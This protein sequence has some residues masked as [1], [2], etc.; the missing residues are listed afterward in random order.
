MLWTF[1]LFFCRISFCWC[2]FFGGR[3]RKVREKSE[4]EL[5]KTRTHRAHRGARARAK[6]VEKKNM[7][8]AKKDS[9]LSSRDDACARHHERTLLFAKERDG[10]GI[11]P[12]RIPSSLW[13]HFSRTTRPKEKRLSLRR[14]RRETERRQN[15]QRLR[16]KKGDREEV[17]SRRP[18][19]E[20][21]FCF[22]ENVR[23]C[24]SF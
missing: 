24:L 8:D 11:P 3:E 12:V 13:G 18:G 21:K 16:A 9:V 15:Y 1:L 7:P 6:D 4:R 17:P 22:G 5:E 19:K 2:V 10:S 23:V 14:A 20:R